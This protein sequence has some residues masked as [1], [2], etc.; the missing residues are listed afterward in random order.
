M[1][2]ML[3]S[4]VFRLSRRAMP[5]VLLLILAVT[6][7]AIFLITWGAA[8][9]SQFTE[10]ERA[11][12]LDSLSLASTL[13]ATLGFAGLFG[14][15]FVIILAAS[16]VATEYTWGTVRTLLPRGSSRM[17]YLGAKLVVL[18][19]FA[20]LVVV[21][22]VA[23]GYASSVVVTSVE[24]LDR[25]LGD[26]FVIDLLVGLGRSWFTMMPY[27]ALAFMVASLAKSSAAGI[28]VATAVLFLEGQILSLLAAAGGVL[29][30]VPELFL[31][32]NA[33]A[34]LAINTDGGTRD[35]PDPWQA[36]TVLAV[37]TVAFLA[38]AAWSF[39]RRDVS[40]G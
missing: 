2:D 25:D 29:E 12:L 31:S 17:A 10:A 33:E 4:E 27:M 6:V 8:Q 19:T 34:L 7:M 35:M 11:D 24:G 38:V 3:R 20:F 13:E 37:Y 21:V 1:L 39:R 36:A 30:R 15:L 40:V 23:S 32:R 9:S 18:A 22:A 28:S 5:R 14:A 16:V 26:R